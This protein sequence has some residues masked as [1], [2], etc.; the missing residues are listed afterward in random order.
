MGIVSL[1]ELKAYL[2]KTTTKDDPELER[3]IEGVT[4]VVEE[5]V[6]QV[7]PKTFIERHP[8]GQKIRLLEQPVISVEAIEPWLDKGTTHAVEGVQLDPKLGKLELR[9]GE[10]F[11]GGPFKVTY[12]A[13]REVIPDSIKT[14]TLIILKHTWETQRG[15]M[16][17][18]PVG[19]GIDNVPSPI[20]ITFSVPRRALEYFRPDNPIMPSVVVA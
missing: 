17:K 9:N 2:N 13:G 18:L 15:Q 1:D 5:Y 4:P 3:F 16:S 12:R 11:T 8:D 6:G 20:G 19:G 7:V 10:P 14:G